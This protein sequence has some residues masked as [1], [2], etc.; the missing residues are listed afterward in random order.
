MRLLFAISVFI[1]FSYNLNAQPVKV[2]LVTGGHSF[3]TVHFL[4]MFDSMNGIEYS[5][6]NQPE[7]NSLIAE[8][9]TG[10]FD[11]LVF[12][13]MWKDLS[14]TEKEAYLNLTRQG[15]P[16]LFLH[17]ALVSYQHWPEFENLLGGRYVENPSLNETRQSTYVH[18]VWINIEIIDTSHPVTEGMDDFRIFDEVYGNYKVLQGVKPLL[19]TDHPKSTSVIGWENRFNASSIIYL[20]PGHDKNTYESEDYRRLIEQAIKYLDGKKES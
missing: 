13:D 16:F 8:G 3:D 14:E 17:H 5:H 2:M 9:K 19:K 4:A 6:Y 1:I 10:N 18:D 20:Q 15:K 11:V 7:A 12:Y